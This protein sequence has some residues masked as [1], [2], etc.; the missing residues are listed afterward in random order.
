MDHV[1]KHVA[2][3]LRAARVAKAMT[4]ED[5]AG[6]LGLATE[7]I[8][9]FERGVSAPSLKMI[10]AAADALDVKMADLF[11]GLKEGKDISRQRADNEAVVRR[12]AYDLDDKSLA[13]LAKI[14][15]AIG[16]QA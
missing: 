5:L 3:T 2:K 8:S 4:Q 15:T 12:L 16:D 7:S 1:I 10:A 6:H 11:V 13:L 14:A 9:H